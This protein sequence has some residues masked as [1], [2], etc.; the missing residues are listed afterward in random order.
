MKKNTTAKI[1]AILAL[2]WIV[3]S[4]V[5]TGILFLYETKFGPN[6]PQPTF[7]DY[8]QNNPIPIDPNFQL[9]VSQDW[10]TPNE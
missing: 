4:I 2:V 7:E 9:P 8:L 1:F 10:D 3:V 5:G 6:V